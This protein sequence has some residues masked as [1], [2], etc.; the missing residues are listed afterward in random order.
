M[1]VE[2]S[3]ILWN[4]EINLT[5]NEGNGTAKNRLRLYVQGKTL[6][7]DAEEGTPVFQII[8]RFITNS[9]AKVLIELLGSDC[10]RRWWQVYS[11]VHSRRG[12]F[13]RRRWSTWRIYSNSCR[14]KISISFEL[15]YNQYNLHIPHS[16]HIYPS[17]DDQKWHSSWSVR[18]Y[19]R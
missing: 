2:L 4:K 11:R 18:R 6:C 13:K 8:I 10:W 12:A 9:P 15:I 14:C 7:I 1:T 5:Y 3:C 19:P 16:G 17:P